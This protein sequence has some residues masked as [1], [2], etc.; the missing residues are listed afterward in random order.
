MINISEIIND[1][2]YARKFIVARAGGGEFIKGRFVPVTNAEIEMIGPVLPYSPQQSEVTPDGDVIGGDMSFL[3]SQKIYTTQ[4]STETEENFL[5]DIITYKGIKYKVLFV[6]D[7]SE[8]GYY[9]AIAKRL[10]PS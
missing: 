3:S 5:S 4:E 7:Y 1:P 9:R 10:N 8:Y 6:R 2:D